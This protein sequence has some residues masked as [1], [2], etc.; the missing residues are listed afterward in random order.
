MRIELYKDLDKEWRWRVI[1]RNGRVVADGPEGYKKRATMLK[2]LRRVKQGW[3]RME[4]PEA[5]E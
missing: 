4:L 1:A 5:I 2:T 3:G